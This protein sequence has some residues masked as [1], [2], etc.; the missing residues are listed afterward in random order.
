MH[1]KTILTSFI[2][3]S[4]VE[5]ANREFVNNNIPTYPTPEQA[6]DAYMYMYQYKRNL[7]LLYETPEETHMDGTPPKRPLMVI[8]REAAKECSEILTEAEAKKL[9]DYYE[10]PVVRTEIATNA[11][12]AI[13]KAVMSKDG[14]EITLNFHG[15]VIVE[16]E[17]EGLA[18]RLMDEIYLAVAR[19]E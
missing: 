15:D 13:V 9:L 12:N 6:V 5:K 18:S 8:M 3:M 2:G 10:I 14:A 7:E 16:T 4:G 1:S 17:D 19:L 11:S